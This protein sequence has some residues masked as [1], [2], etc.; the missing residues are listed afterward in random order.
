MAISR[1]TSAA[2]D[3]PSWATAWAEIDL[4]FK[5]ELRR[6]GLDDPI[7]WAGLVRGTGDPRSKLSRALTALGFLAVGPE[8]LAERLDAA[9][10][11]HQAAKEATADWAEETARVS[12]TQVTTGL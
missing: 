3:S 8:E 11:L 9:V 4:G 10:A 2:T 6:Q 7:V 5:T 1:I 12:N